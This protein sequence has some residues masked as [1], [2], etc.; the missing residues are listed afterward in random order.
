MIL[1]RVFSILTI[2]TLNNLVILHGEP[3]CYD[4]S[5]E[6]TNL[7]LATKTP[8]RFISNYNDSVVTYPGCHPR[9]IW[10]V[11]RHGTRN[12]KRKIID[13]IN[14]KLT[15]IRN[16]II[17]RRNPKLCP[18]DIERLRSWESQINVDEEKHLTYE[19]NDEL[20]QL[21]ERVQNR[22]P[23]IL[24]EQFDESSYKFK[25]TDSQ[26]TWKSFESFASGLFGRNNLSKVLHAP[27]TKRDPI[28]RFY[29]LCSKWAVDVDDNP[30]AAHEPNEWLKSDEMNNLM[31]EMRQKLDLP[32]L[33][34]GDIVLMYTACGF[35]TAWY[36]FNS[37]PWCS[38]FTENQLKILEF[39]FDLKHYWNDGYGFEI[40]KM[41]ACPAL[42]DMV[43]HLDLNSN[44]PN[45][46]FYFTHS[47]ALL[48]ILAH[49]GLYRDDF[50]L[51]H[52]DFG[53]NREWRVGK[54]D[55]FASNLV[56]VSFECSSE[57]YVLVMH[58][59]QIVTLPGCPSDT[60]LCSLATIRKTFEGSLNECDFDDLCENA[61]SVAP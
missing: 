47:G 1:A 50:T 16:E 13:A 32:S 18:Q 48:K 44:H 57:P 26:R 17:E 42:K 36:K 59:E 55:A 5:K 27:P 49:L 46:T 12:P 51:T 25:F 34:K 19:G 10:S 20:L 28:L 58:Q 37:S 52:K 29:K 7:H 11:I 2:V 21:A 61:K 31:Q 15:N 43:D 40:N 4:S 30:D 33:S 6:N 45:S 24:P 8:Y 54:I 39:Y 53:K 60:D 14:I 3:T 56:F 9:R 38:I 23:S 35:E 22:F 41:Q